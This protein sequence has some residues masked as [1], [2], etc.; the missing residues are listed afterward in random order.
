LIVVQ[1]GELVRFVNDGFLVHMDAWGPDK[2]VASAKKAMALLL[3]GKDNKAGKLFTVSP[4]AGAGPLSSGGL[5]QMVVTAPSGICVQAC[6]MDPQDGRE[7]T[8][9]GMGRMIKV[10]K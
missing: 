7:H 6:F 9:P 8:Q 5:E 4:T 3:A 2:N 10:L 1:Y